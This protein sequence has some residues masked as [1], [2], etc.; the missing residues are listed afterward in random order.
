MNIHEIVG[1]RGWV[2]EDGSFGNGNIILFDPSRLTDKQ[3]N[4]LADLSDSMKFE[5]VEAILDGKNLSEWE[6]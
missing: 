4:T 2:A 5:Y 6:G 3:W 1:N